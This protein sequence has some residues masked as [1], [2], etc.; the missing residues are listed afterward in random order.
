MI[1]A[2]RPG[3]GAGAEPSFEEAKTRL[4]ARVRMHEQYSV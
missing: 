3:V 2:A 4:H 1:A